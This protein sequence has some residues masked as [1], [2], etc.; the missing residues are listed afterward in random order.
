M[1]TNENAGSDMAAASVWN[2]LIFGIVRPVGVD[3]DRFTSALS[4]QLA[5]FGFVVERIRL[6]QSYRK[7]TWGAFQQRRTFPRATELTLSLTPATS[8]A[9]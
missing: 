9:N 2:E 6:S 7:P 8:C 4:Q 1:P 5:A 3:R